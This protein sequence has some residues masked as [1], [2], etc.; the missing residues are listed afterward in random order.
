MIPPSAQVGSVATLVLQYVLPEGAHLPDKARIKG[1]EGLT[2]LGLE[3]I[4]R[5]DGKT[6]SE[7]KSLSGEIR[8]RLL[9]DRLRT[10]TTGPLSVTFMDKQGGEAVL[11]APPVSLSVL[12]NLG[13]KPE[14]A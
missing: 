1:L 14:E 2:I 9:V 8:V 13:E 7:E 5:A 4:P 10:L 6:G 11:D 12:S 3:N